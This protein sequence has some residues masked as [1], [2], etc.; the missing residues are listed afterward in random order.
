M[1]LKFPRF[2]RGTVMGLKFP[3]FARGTVMGLKFLRFA[4]G[5][6]V[7]RRFGSPCGHGEPQGGGWIRKPL[8]FARRTQ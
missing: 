8:P 1:G 2:A 7:G 6:A 5:T 4:R 3:R